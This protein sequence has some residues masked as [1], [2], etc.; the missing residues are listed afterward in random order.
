MPAIFPSTGSI[1]SKRES[2]SFLLVSYI[3]DPLIL[4]ISTGVTGLLCTAQTLAS[5]SFI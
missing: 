4:V 2:I 5:L 3:N 1:I